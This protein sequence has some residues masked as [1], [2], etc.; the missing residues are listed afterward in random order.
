MLTDKLLGILVSEKFCQNYNKAITLF[1]LDFHEAIYDLVF[2]SCIIRPLNCQFRKK[3]KFYPS[4][5]VIY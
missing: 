5:C 4:F 1:T 3:I 2:G